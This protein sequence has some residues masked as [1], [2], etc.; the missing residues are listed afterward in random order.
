MLAS[1][2]DAVR[3]TDCDSDAGSGALGGLTPFAFGVGAPETGL[4]RVAGLGTASCLEVVVVLVV[5]VKEVDLDAAAAPAAD[6][7]GAARRAGD[8]PGGD[9]GAAPFM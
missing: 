7:G 2:T 3:L 1:S 9:R 5:P 4:V 6:M 8:F